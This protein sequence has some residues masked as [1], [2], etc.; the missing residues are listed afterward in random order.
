MLVS[1][2]WAGNCNLLG[3][4]A[5]VAWIEPVHYAQPLVADSFRNALL[6]C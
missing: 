3:L 1:A 5:L 2:V 4:L 6:E